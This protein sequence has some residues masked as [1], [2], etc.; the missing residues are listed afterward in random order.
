M[1][2]PI[3]NI[4]LDGFRGATAS[5]SLNFD[6]QKDLTLLF[7]ENGS[8]KSTIL[9]A[10]DVVCNGGVG[11]LQGISVGTQPGQFL[12]TYGSS[13]AN[14]KVAVYS[15]EK[16]WTGTIVGSSISVS[17]EDNK[18]LVKILRR[19]HILDLVVAQPHERYGALRRFIDIDTIERSEDNL[20]REV[21]SASGNIDRLIQEKAQS[22]SQLEEV[23][24]AE[25]EPAETQSATDWAEQKIRVGIGGLAEQLKQL[26][27]FVEAIGNVVTSKDNHVRKTT[28]LTSKQSESSKVRQ[29]IA[30]A[31]GLKTE[32]A[33]LLIDSLNKAKSYIEGKSDVD[34]CPTCLRPIGR[35]KLL[36]VVSDQLDQMKE[37]S[38]LNKRLKSAKREV[39][40]AASNLAQ[41]ESSFVDSVQK[42]EKISAE[43]DIPEMA[44]LC[45]SWPDWEAE[46]TDYSSL[47]SVGESVATIL[48]SV[49]AK[50]DAVQKDVNQFTSVYQ[51]HQSIK[52]S[53]K[54]A[55]SLKRIK[56]GLQKAHEIVH[57]KRIQFVQGILDE[58]AVEANRLFQAIHPGENIGLDQLKMDESRRASVNQSG[59]FHGH[60][61]IPP[62]AIF[63]E[64][65]MDTL[66]F[67][68]WLALAKKDHPED[69]ILLID[70]VFT[71]V[72]AKHLSRIANLMT[73]ESQHF[74]QVIMATHFRNLLDQYRI[75]VA[76]SGRVQL[77]ELNSKWTPEK[78]IRA[79]GILPEVRVIQ[80]L[81]NEG[82]VNRQ[83]L[84]SKT[85]ILLEAVLGQI[86]MQ[87][88]CR[89]AR[90]P[91]NEPTLGPLMDGASSLFKDK[92]KLQRLKPCKDGSEDWEEIM[93]KKEFKAVKEC[94]FRQKHGRMPL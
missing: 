48:T 50:R 77:I 57:A 42:L 38:L 41:A 83:E 13:V 45:I 10:V 52:Q 54:D 53:E 27:D 89:V 72:D 60:D 39:E 25:K 36:Q 51:W 37:L 5:F 75:G 32:S 88:A 66:G 80:D 91:H 29:L 61:N 3:S 81:L 65:H 21:D 92:L 49:K 18:P 84:A 15:K 34:Q 14:L 6:S 47:V 86:T 55:E 64:S 20:K 35:D 85:G 62:Q 33:I 71:S 90:D 58:I 12:P 56:E 16:K 23:W 79:R 69:V 8:G 73:E 2:K 59:V 87:C 68:V 9:D 40:I 24:R 63:S 74:C 44:K 31:P 94:N 70:D 11:S 30:D 1:G 93:A 78:G 22:L 67:S 43:K 28:D 46:E 4:E 19:R 17:P 82:F 76:A 7:G 26:N